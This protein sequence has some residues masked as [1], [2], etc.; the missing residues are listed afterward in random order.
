[1]DLHFFREGDRG[2][3]SGHNDTIFSCEFPLH[4]LWIYELEGTYEAMMM[5]M[6]NQAF[7]ILGLVFVFL[8]QLGKSSSLSVEA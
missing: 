2:G 1:M 8:V 7:W 3:S 5:S 4:F 6:Y